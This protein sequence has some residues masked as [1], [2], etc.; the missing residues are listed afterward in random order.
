MKRG[1]F[2][3]G[4]LGAIGLALI[5]MAA[6]DDDQQSSLDCSA[7]AAATNVDIQNLPDQVAGYTGKPLRNAA[8]IASIAA[9]TGMGRRGQ[10]IGLITAIQES[11]LGRDPTCTTPN[12][13]GDAGVFQQRVYDGWYGS[14]AMVNDITYA[15]RAFYLG[16]TAK[17]ATDYG[18]VGGGSGYGHIP[19]LKDIDGWEQLPLTIAAANVQR[20]DQDL[21]GE[22]AKHENTAVELL[23][24]LSNTTV[25][26][27]SDGAGASD[28]GTAT[29]CD[30]N[31]IAPPPNGT[32]ATAIKRARDLLGT[33]YVWGG[34][35][36]NGVD[37]SG[38]VVYAFGLNIAQ[39]GRTAQQQYDAM[40]AYNVPLDQIQPGDLIFE[41]WG[42]RGTVGSGNA[43]SHVAIYLGQNQMIEASQSAQKVK[44]SPVRFGSS[45]FVGIRR[46]PT[47]TEQP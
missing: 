31:G 8:V 7:D 19:G 47:V 25:T 44:Y 26:P 16:V 1:A 36:S 42:R 41:A 3:A 6:I 43:V 4:G 38:L 39:H 17:T 24:G 2:L 20:P 13:D 34:E 9:S 28:N 29:A 35:N 32:V 15:A 14:L 46:V 23:A 40:A 11:D 5:G 12:S 21:L 10:I 33:P 30:P 37:C 18:S 45:A 22:Y 27:S